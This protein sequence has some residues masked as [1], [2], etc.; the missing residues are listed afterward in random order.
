LSTG[1]ESLLYISEMKKQQNFE[2]ILNSH[3][4]KQPRQVRKPVKPAL[5]SQMMKKQS[6]LISMP[7]KDE[8]DGDALQALARA[9]KQAKGQPSLEEHD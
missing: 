4:A 8:D 1:R 3:G 7:L 9:A 5:M 2:E 6:V